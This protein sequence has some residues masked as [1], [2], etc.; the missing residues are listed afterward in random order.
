MSSKRTTF[1][2]SSGHS[3]PNPISSTLSSGVPHTTDRRPR[4]TQTG[5]WNAESLWR[6]LLAISCLLIMARMC[7]KASYSDYGL[8]KRLS[9][10]TRSNLFDATLARPQVFSQWTQLLNQLPFS[11]SETEAKINYGYVI[12]TL[13]FM[14]RMWERYRE[15]RP[16]RSVGGCVSN[17]HQFI[18]A[19]LQMWHCVPCQDGKNKTRFLSE[20]LFHEHRNEHEAD[21]QIAGL[22]SCYR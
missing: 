18:Q 21:Y 13:H 17:L 19:F 6:K 14:A 8:S 7:L 5:T 3:F 10:R 4:R 22:Y 12:T 15:E 11:D 9:C 20:G 16:L 2:T 1:P